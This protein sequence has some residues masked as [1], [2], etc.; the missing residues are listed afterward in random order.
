MY[1]QP[2]DHL[3]KL[4]FEPPLR[5]VRELI[6]PC[7]D[8]SIIFVRSN[9]V[10]KPVVVSDIF[11][12]WKRL[13]EAG[14]GRAVGVVG[15]QSIASSSSSSR[16]RGCDRDC[17]CGSGARVRADAG[18][19]ADDAL[20]DGGLKVA[21]LREGC[22][23]TGPVACHVRSGIGAEERERLSSSSGGS[24]ERRVLALVVIEVVVIAVAVVA[25]GGGEREGR[26]EVL[27]L[28]VLEREM[29]E[30]IRRTAGAR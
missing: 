13:R 5:L 15:V 1:T 6:L 10:S 19:G 4:L 16:D 21:G 18:A 26:E 22:P 24:R 9:S 8:L 3:C 29:D 27:V 2:H 30:S 7:S 12:A 25:G 20:G 14:S 17:D 28:G 23:K 11:R